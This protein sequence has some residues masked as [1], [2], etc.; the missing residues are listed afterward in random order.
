M[1]F[2]TKSLSK[3]FGGNK[4]EKDIKGIEPLVV[5]SNEI[6]AGLRSLSNDALRNKT[7]EFKVKI[8]DYLKSADEQIASLK[9]QADALTIDEV[10]KKDTIYKEADELTKN[11]DKLIEEVLMEILPEA[12]AVMKETARRFT[13]NT[14]LEV[15]A[16]QLDR[17]LSVG[18]DFIEINGDKAIYKNEWTAAGGYIKWNM[19]HYDVQLIGG[20]VLHQGKISEMATGEGKTLVATLPAYLNALP[21]LGVH[22]VTVNTYL[23]QR[24]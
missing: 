1:N 17:D 22:I 7:T 21:G 14:T 4:Y 8:S 9:L 10:E 6:F 13:E 5:K 15:T 24:D 11:R 18:K 16:T 2:L 19:V 3:L 23:S 12:F 20:I